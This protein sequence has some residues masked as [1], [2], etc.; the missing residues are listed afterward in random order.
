MT[1]NVNLASGTHLTIA[2]IGAIMVV[3][4][5][6]AYSGANQVSDLRHRLEMLELKGIAEVTSLKKDLKAVTQTSTSSSVAIAKVQR[7][8]DALADEVIK[9]RSRK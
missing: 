9:M 3:V 2:Q 6:L 7:Q 1:D 8:V 5:G 4:G